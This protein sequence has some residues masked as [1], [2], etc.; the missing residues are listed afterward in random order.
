MVQITNTTQLSTFTIIRGILISNSVLSGK[1][2][3]QDFYEFEPRHKSNDFKGFPY[4]VV[5]VPEA[6]E[7]E[8]V[9]GDILKNKEFTVNIIM[10]VD[11]HARSNFT[12]YASNIVKE[13]DA[14]NSTF[15]ANGYHLE[16]VSFDGSESLVADQKQLIEGTF[17]LRL[18]GEV[19]T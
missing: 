19:V 5:M 8:A 13:L 4:I 7:S 1:F 12:S 2:R 10:R 11:Y 6:E 17:T 15:M 18:Q 9:L 14:A 16:S 3:L